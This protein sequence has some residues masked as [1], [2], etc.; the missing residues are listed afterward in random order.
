MKIVA[1]FCETHNDFLGKNGEFRLKNEENE[2]MLHTL[3]CY[4]LMLGSNKLFFLL[5]FM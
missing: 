1:R 5:N 2:K 4:Q 3:R